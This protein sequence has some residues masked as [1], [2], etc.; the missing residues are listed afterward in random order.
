MSVIFVLDSTGRDDS[1]E[2]VLALIADSTVQNLLVHWPVAPTVVV[3]S[4]FPARYLP[5]LYRGPVQHWFSGP[6]FG[7]VPG[8]ERCSSFFWV[9][10]VILQWNTVERDRLGLSLDSCLYRFCALFFC[11]AIILDFP[12]LLVRFMYTSPSKE[13]LQCYEAIKLGREGKGTRDTFF[14]WPEE[15]ILVW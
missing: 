11:F 4:I 5:S 3:L 12:Y 15:K 14:S 13:S 9:C 1:S 2:N 6:C 8:I 10:T 7:S